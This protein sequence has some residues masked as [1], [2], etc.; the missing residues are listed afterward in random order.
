MDPAGL[1]K[2]FGDRI[3]FWGGGVDSQ[4]VLP[5]L[6]PTEVREHTKQNIEAFKP[7]GGY[8][9]NNVHNIQKGIPPENIISMY[10]AGFDFGFYR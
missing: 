3:V 10:E 1:K 6:S 7:G 4:H 2:K 5:F 8:V 9:F